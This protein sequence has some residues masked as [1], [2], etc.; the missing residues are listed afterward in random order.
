MVAREALGNRTLV[1]AVTEASDEV[2]RGVPLSRALAS[3]E[4]LFPT[5]AVEMISVSE[6]TGRTVATLQ[7]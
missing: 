5:S 1:D 2:Q 4:Q 3:H 6:E 7:D